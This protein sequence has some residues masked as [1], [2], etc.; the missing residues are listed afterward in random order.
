MEQ[1]V[2]RTCEVC[3]DPLPVDTVGAI[4]D[5]CMETINQLTESEETECAPAS[6]EEVSSSVMPDETS[7]E[8]KSMFASFDALDAIS[9]TE[10]LSQTSVTQPLTEAS[11]S[12]TKPKSPC[13]GCG[14]LDV[15]LTSFKHPM[16]REALLLCTNCLTSEKALIEHKDDPMQGKVVHPDEASREELITMDDADKVLYNEEVRFCID[17]PIEQVYDRISL[18]EERLKRAK[19]LLK[20]SRT[21]LFM[22][23]EH[24]KKDEQEAEYK[25]L[26]ERDKTRRARTKPTSS[27]PKAPG[28]A[29]AP[30]RTKADQFRQSMEANGFPAEWINEQIKKMGL[31]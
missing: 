14:A 18:L 6:A 27:G 7:I 26:N 30:K 10:S 12:S 4:C 8:D 2:E 16:A 15:E 31:V 24:M 20:A 19:V 11:E 21:T 5:N 23:I 13:D 25:R 22:R 1:I 3:L 9:D 28:T 17:T 29:R